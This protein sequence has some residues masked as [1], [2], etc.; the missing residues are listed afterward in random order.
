MKTKLITVILALSLMSPIAVYAD[1]TTNKVSST[2][3]KVT[4]SKADNVF[5]LYTKKD[6]HGGFWTLDVPHNMT[7]KQAQKYYIGKH[8]DIYYEGDEQTDEEIEI[9]ESK[10]Y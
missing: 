1:V 4:Y 5:Y 8:V 7:L 6:S 9:V 3:V 2:I 10:I